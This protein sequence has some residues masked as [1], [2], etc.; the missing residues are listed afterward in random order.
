MLIDA[1]VAGAGTFHITDLSGNLINGNGA[2]TGPATSQRYFAG[3]Y[4]VTG[5]TRIA[6][7]NQQRAGGPTGTG[8]TG[9][10]GVE[11]IAHG[12]QTTI[13]AAFIV[14]VNKNGKPCM[15]TAVLDPTNPA[16]AGVLRVFDGSGTGQFASG[17]V[18][19]YDGNTLN[20]QCRGQ[21]TAQIV[22]GGTYA[23]LAE[24]GDVSGV[25]SNGAWAVSSLNGL[26][27]RGAQVIAGNADAFLRTISIGAFGLVFNTTA[28][29]NV[30]SLTI[31]SSSFLISHTGDAN[32]NSIAIG[33]VPGVSRSGG[34][35]ITGFSTTT[36]TAGSDAGTVVVTGITT[37]AQ[38]FT[39]GIRSL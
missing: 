12:A 32:L 33:G 19:F 26:Q 23:R 28:D 10:I 24:I 29:A 3:V 14:L 30:N 5:N 13:G 18:F 15:S 16:S 25:D 27:L 6:M 39:G 38:T 22:G 8:V 7:D 9:G 35:E 34:F 17:E 21:F 37:R 1:G 2:F 11:D 4:V 20:G 31:A 36:L